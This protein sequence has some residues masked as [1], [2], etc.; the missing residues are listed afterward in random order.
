MK[1]NLEH[2]RKLAKNGPFL[3]IKLKR[4]QTKGTIGCESVQYGPIGD[5]NVKHLVRRGPMC[6]AI[7]WD[8]SDFESL[9]RTPCLVSG[10]EN[11][12]RVADLGDEASKLHP[13]TQLWWRK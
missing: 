1:T 3:I 11:S 4:L 7:E 5:A 2:S 13:C 12:D 9:S 6:L 8:L 10:H